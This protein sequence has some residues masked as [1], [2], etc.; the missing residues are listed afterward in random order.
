KKMKK[1][2][3]LYLF[4]IA[5]SF[6]SY[7]QTVNTIIDEGIKD[8]YSLNFTAAETKFRTLLRDN[9]KSPA[10]LFYLSMI[11][12]WKI[13]VDLDD[14]SKDDL[15][16][17]KLDDVIYVCDEIL[18]D[19]PNNI[20]ALF[21]KGGAI[22]FR[23]RLHALRESWLKAADDGREALPIVNRVLK[24]QPGNADILLGTGIYSYYV[25][26]IPDEYPA[27]KPLLIF[28]PSGDKDLGIKDLKRVAEKGRYAKYEAQYFLMTLYQEFEKDP[29]S[30]EKY[31]KMLTDQ[32]PDNPVFLKW[33][34]RAAVMRGDYPLIKEIYTHLYKGASEGKF[35][36][37]QKV[38]RETT[39]YL[40]FYY[41]AT[42]QWDSSLVYFKEA[43]DLSKKIE[44]GDASGYYVNSLLY[45]GMMHDKLLQREEAIKCY[46]AVLELKDY[47]S[48]HKLAKLHI[49]E[50]YK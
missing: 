3:I 24:I 33:R 26:V 35:G 41:K 5:L 27:V 7:S 9:P 17:K 32:F 36:Y 29:N 39:Y 43:V 44:K 49:N 45:Q 25:S 12:W 28:F 6:Q 48:S 47:S 15:F 10:G 34:G 16:Y 18:D 20:D 13:L 22:G 8:V 31:A 40:G 2:K 23:G 42:A 19:D 1:N 4:L 37:S 46:Y 21:F 50:P 11:D 14:E 38:K 30:S